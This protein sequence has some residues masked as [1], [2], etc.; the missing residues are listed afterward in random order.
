MAQT[1]VRTDER[2]GITERSGFTGSGEDLMFVCLHVPQQ[3]ALGVTVICP[4]ILNDF[5]TNYRRE[6]ML[7]RELASHGIA[8]ARFHYRGTGHS[9]GERFAMTFDGCLGDAAEATAFAVRET[10]AARVAFLGTR[11]GAFAAASAATS[12][13]DAPVAL[14]EPTLAPERFFREG[15]RANLATEVAHGTTETARPSIEDE[16][17]ATGVANLASHTLPRSLYESSAGRTL[18]RELGEHGRP[19]LLVQFGWSRDLKRPNRNLVRQLGERGFVVTTKTRGPVEPWWM[20]RTSPPADR[21]V[22]VD[23][24]H[25]LRSQ[26]TG[27]A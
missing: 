3:R 26:L 13:P 4:S 14:W 24:A 15:V 22:I 12:H 10:S 18:D 8:V 25:W 16:I 19:V 1:A 6:V 23:T 20:E 27:A 21:A 9:D 2:L 7:A 5:F 11:W 17:A